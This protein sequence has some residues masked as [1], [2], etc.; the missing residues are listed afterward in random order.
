MAKT[1]EVKQAKATREDVELL[2]KFMQFL[3]SFVEKA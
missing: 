3:E 1:V 2:V